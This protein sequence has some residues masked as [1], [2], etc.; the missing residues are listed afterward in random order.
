M[1]KLTET[2]AIAA[3]SFCFYVGM[4]CIINGS[5]M[6]NPILGWF[7]TGGLLCVLAVIGSILPGDQPEQLP[8]ED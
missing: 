2:R 4:A 5:W 3:R 1:K 7:V 6:L 8:K